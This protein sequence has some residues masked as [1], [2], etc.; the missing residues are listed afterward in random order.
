MYETITTDSFRIFSSSQKETLCP[1]AITLIASSI[2]QHRTITNLLSVLR[3]LCTGFSKKWNDTVSGLLWL[4]SFGINF[5]N[6]SNLLH[7]SV[8]YS[9]LWLNCIPLCGYIQLCCFIHQLV[10]TWIVS[11]FWL[12][13]IM[14]LYNFMHKFLCVHIFSF[15]LDK[16]LG[17]ELL[18]H[19]ITLCF[20]SC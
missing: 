8:F 9:Y 10:D 2:L 20:K 4:V 11:T 5:Q 3:F 1:S 18:S 14:F 16:Y 15:L 13:Q 19:M 12:L 7:A 6:S 17:A